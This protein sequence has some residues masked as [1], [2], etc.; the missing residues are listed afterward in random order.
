MALNLDDLQ[1]LQR[2]RLL[3]E[4]GSAPTTMQEVATRLGI[5]RT[6][7]YR[8]RNR[9]NEQLEGDLEWIRDGGFTLPAEVFRL[10]RHL[11]ADD[12][13]LAGT[14]F[15]V[16]SVG[17]TAKLLLTEYILRRNMPAPRLRFRRSIDAASALRCR[18]IDLALLNR[19]DDST[20]DEDVETTSNVTSGPD[21]TEITLRQWTACCV[22]PFKNHEQP[23]RRVFWQNGSFAARL[24]RLASGETDRPGTG[25]VNAPAS[26]CK[27]DS[28]SI[29]MH[30]YDV[31]LQMLRRGMPVATTVPSIYLLDNDTERFQVLPATVPVS[32]RLIAFIRQED[33][34]R[35]SSWLNQETWSTI[36]LPVEQL[37][38]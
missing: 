24:D 6:L 2:L 28:G 20:I 26:E 9:V 31:A 4:S 22:R 12:G 18:E 23:V 36:G 29:Q 16:V 37:S 30:G 7:L 21:L 10:T 27:A 17:S 8:L 5:Q 38:F 19:V 1:L 33:Q 32:G 25:K 35:L 15:P 13:E 14:G 3:I 34:Q 11:L